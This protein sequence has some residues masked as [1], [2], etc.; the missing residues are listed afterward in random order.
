MNTNQSKPIA[1]S[2][3]PVGRVGGYV[4]TFAKRVEGRERR[5]LGEFFGL[6]NFGIN[7][8]R[9]KPGSESALLHKHSK[10]DEF[11]YI[12]EGQP[13]LNTSSAKT[14]LTPHMCVGFPADGEAHHLVNDT[15]EDVLYLEIGDRTPRDSV[16]YPDDDLM[17]L[18][19]EEGR[20]YAHKDGRRY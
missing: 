1:S 4:G 8:T 5:A 6:G 17:L 20:V 2:A 18:D 12:L 9:L 11:V 15:E 13:A 14:R 3:I 16:E 10:Q 7:L 19:T